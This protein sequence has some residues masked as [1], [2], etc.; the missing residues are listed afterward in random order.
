MFSRNESQTIVLVVAACRR[1]VRS[2]GRFSVAVALNCC[3]LAAVA[4]SQQDFTLSAGP[5]AAPA[6]AKLTPA[7]LTIRAETG[8][9]TF[10]RR[11]REFDSVDAQWLGYFSD[12]AA[13]VIRWPASNQG[14]LQ[15]GRLVGSQPQYRAS[16]MV[17]EP[18]GGASA[19]QLGFLP[20]RL[21]EA[22]GAL[23]GLEGFKTDPA[24]FSILRGD[25]GADTFVALQLATYNT[26]GLARALIRSGVNGLSSVPVS[27]SLTEHWWLAPAGG[28]MLRLETYSAGS[29]FAISAGSQHRVQM[30][31]LLQDARQ[32]WRPI[33]SP[34]FN[35]L[36]SF[37]N[38]FFPGQC[39]TVLPDNRIVLQPLA[40][41]GNQFWL[42]LAPFQPPRMGPF[43]RR[44]RVD[45][46]ANPP[47]EP[48]EVKLQNTHR[49][50]LLLLIGDSKPTEPVKFLRIEPGAVETVLLRRESGSTLTEAFETLLPDGT[51]EL[52]EFVTPIPAAG[53]FDVSVYEQHLQSIAIDRTGKSPN[54]IEDVNYA[55]K[56]IGW[57]SLPVGDGLQAQPVIDVY[58]TAR[59]AGN[60]GA[61]R[62]LP[63]SV[64]DENTTGS[65]V[66]D[67]LKQFQSVPRRKF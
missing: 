47:L 10:Y 17:I 34:G 62:R 32:L 49:T 44:S 3:W 46:V 9:V 16:Q 5:S 37:E 36:Y 58:R 66:E 21:P 54:P 8:T 19:S 67:I 38:A 13:Q 42:P 51:W 53:F 7:G 35:Y 2:I 64:I 40:F 50:A 6:Q 11:A 23:P 43:V 28:G 26:S 63:T 56:S 31:P 59:D 15:I 33:R 4:W 22:G 57:F 18:S 24:L 20:A 25:A 65:P 60:P 61:V 52:Q 27:S 30:Q 55:A 12:A 39:L 14:N 29:V 48:A 41:Q 1:C 45:V